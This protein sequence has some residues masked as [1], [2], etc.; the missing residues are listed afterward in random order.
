MD[1]KKETH[2]FKTEVQQMLNLIINSLYSNK[3]I[4]LRELISNASDAIDKVR[5][6]AETEPG[7][8][9]DDTELKIHLKPDAIKQTFEISDNGIGMTLD[10]V[11][12]NIGTIA[13]SGT[14]A[15]MEALEQ[16][17]GQETLI[18]ELIGQFGVGFYSAF[19]VADKI[20]LVTRAAGTAADQAVKWV[21]T[22]DGSYTTET[23]EKATRGTT[24]TLELKKKGKDDKDFTD[25]W[26]IRNIVKQHSDFV[27]Y[28]ITME[29]E[30]DEPLPDEEI[31]KDKDGKP[32]GATTRK[33]MR[34]ETLNSMKAIWTRSS[35][36]VKDEE[37]EEFY[38]HLSHDWNAPMERLHLKFEGTTEYHALLYIPSKAPFDLFTPERR[39]GIHLYSKRVFIMDDCKELMP[40]YFRFVKGVVDA[41]DLNLNVSREILQQDRLVINIRKNLVKKLFD[42]LEKMEDEKYTQFYD[43]FGAVLKEGIYT[44]PTRKEKIAGLARYKTTKSEGKWVSLDD[45]VKNMAADQKEIYYITGDKLSA[46]LNS[47]HLEKLKEKDFEVLL[48]T[49]PVDEWV[50]QSLTEYDGKPL[51][52]AEKGDLELDAV[53]DSKKEAYNALFGFI[54]GTLEEKIKEVKPSSRLKDSVSCLSGDAW[55]TSAYMEKL[56]KASGQ[57]TPESKRVLELNMDHPVVEKIKSLFESDRDN[58]ALKDYSHLLFD[59]AVVGEGGKLDNPARFSKMVG[60]LMARAM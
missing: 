47:P 39:H 58:P 10:E 33:V 18:P 23:V 26:V 41:S 60:D 21:S 27:S 4:F 16:A 53:D 37:Y 11:L 48:M 6:K 14:A 19:M 46:L 2:Q 52:S 9:G 36:E 22:G 28:P 49:D 3:D 56:L 54:K 45:Y 50:V 12:E 24:I 32:I 43:E 38:K 31:I 30:R 20:T 51:K 29:V 44:D 5:Y 59:M 17:K 55:D 7:I 25:Q 1:A 57:K 40:E 34:E 13:K 8:L 15:F 42:L 35:S